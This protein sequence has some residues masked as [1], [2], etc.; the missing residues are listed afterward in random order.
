V[1]GIWWAVSGSYGVA[2]EKPWV[3][4]CTGIV[5]LALGREGDGGDVGIWAEG[6]RESWGLGPGGRM[7]F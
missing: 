2:V 1:V 5:C 4:T 3:F 7:R 6:W